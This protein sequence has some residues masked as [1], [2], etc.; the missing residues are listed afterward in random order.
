MD[1]ASASA[2]T[3]GYNVYL[4]YQK[5]VYNCDHSFLQS[6]M[7]WLYSSVDSPYKFRFR[8]KAFININHQGIQ[9]QK[10]NLLASLTLSGETGGGPRELSNWK[11]INFNLK[12]LKEIYV[13]KRH[14]DTC[15]LVSKVSSSSSTPP[16][17][18]YVWKA[19]NPS[20]YQSFRSPYS[21]NSAYKKSYLL[22]II[23]FKEGPSR[24]LQSI[25]S[26]DNILADYNKKD[27]NKNQHVQKAMNVKQSS[28][29][30]E[31]STS[32]D[33]TSNVDRPSMQQ[34]FSD[35]F[36]KQVQEQHRTL[37][38]YFGNSQSSNSASFIYN[39]GG[40]NSLKSKQVLTNSG[41][42]N[43]FSYHHQRRL[44]VDS[45]QPPQH[46]AS[47][48]S[49]HFMNNSSNL[50]LDNYGQT[51]Q[52]GISIN[53]SGTISRQSSSNDVRPL[54]A[55]LGGVG[56]GA[57]GNGGHRFFMQNN[58]ASTFVNL[59][60]NSL[61]QFYSDQMHQHNFLNHPQYHQYLHGHHNHHHP[62]YATLS[63][64]SASSVPASPTPAH[65]QK[66]SKSNWL[67]GFANVARTHSRSSSKSSQINNGSVISTTPVTN[68]HRND[69]N[70]S[71]ENLSEIGYQQYKKKLSAR[72]R[73]SGVPLAT[74]TSS[75]KSAEKFYSTSNHNNKTPKG[76]SN[77]NLHQ[78]NAFNTQANT[79]NSNQSTNGSNQLTI[80]KGSFNK[81]QDS[82]AS[83]LPITHKNQN[84]TSC[85]SIRNHRLNQNMLHYPIYQNSPT[86]Q[87]TNDKQLTN[88]DDE[89]N[90]ARKTK[91]RYVM[92]TV[93]FIRFSWRDF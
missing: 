72:I 87:K 58:S 69:V 36:S 13:D 33:A 75:L 80:G 60:N 55:H 18:N 66:F 57:V 10:D 68:H 14:K 22:T 9:I 81:K 50:S 59:N 90:W 41:T 38:N 16:T 19:S 88:Q 76:N 35:Y 93:K 91:N 31:M 77:L 8:N 54:Y 70:T 5:E 21:L 28:N 44:S 65:H 74:S 37:P 12:H 52:N 34:Y 49:L 4:I 23:K 56:A 46:I 27:L 42:P 20:N 85:L 64:S 73:S 11:S 25:Q 17:N 63:K 51:H 62:H 79:M 30:N 47:L 82:S 83:S 61:S 29:E 7:D 40:H 89:L 92:P 67:N 43:S 53:R 71:N 32:L 2:A 6:M 45:S 26:L 48:T 15:V 24:L 84:D 39:S 1:T 78:T 86:Q 3:N